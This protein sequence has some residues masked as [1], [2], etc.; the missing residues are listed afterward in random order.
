VNIRARTA[1]AESTCNRVTIAVLLKWNL[2]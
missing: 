1:G 2:T